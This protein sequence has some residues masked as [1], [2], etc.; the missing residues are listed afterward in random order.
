[1]Q[2][3]N[4]FNSRER[5]LTFGVQGTGKSHAILTVARMTPDSTFYVIDTD[6]SE[7]YEVAL[8]TEF[9]DLANVQVIKVGYDNWK[10]QLA[11]IETVRQQCDRDDWL[12]FDTVS[13]TWDAV[14]KWYMEE[15]FEQG[16]DEYFMEVRKQKEA[17]K[18]KA[19][20]GRDGGGKKESAKALGALEGWMDWPVINAQYSPLYARLTSMPCHLYLTAEQAQ[21]GGDDDREVKAMFGPYGVKPRGQKR[22][23]HVPRTV[24][25]MTKSRAGEY[26]VTTI[27]DRNRV[28]MEDLEY[29][30]F[31]KDYL[32]KIG[33]WKKK[34][35]KGSGD[36]EGGDGEDGSS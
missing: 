1:M 5:I 12:I 3:V 22:L 21:T 25:W 26:S 35:V 29:E 7:S 20:G 11:A 15:I 9:A 23:G 6:Y 8:E 4:P 31:A 30:D 2:L 24:L 36:G 19:E 17:Q 10:D 13:C 32:V 14:Q 16:A 33:G 28:E 18:R 34:Y 27:K